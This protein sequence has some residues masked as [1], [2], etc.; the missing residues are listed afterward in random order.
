MYEVKPAESENGKVT[1]S[2]KNAA[3]G[4]EVTVTVTPNDGYELDKLVVKDKDGNEIEVT[5]KDGKYTFTMPASEVEITAEFKEAEP[6]T[7]ATDG[8]PFVDVP[9]DAYFRKAVE[10][11]LE[12]GV[13]GGTSPTTFSPKAQATRGQTMTFLWVSARP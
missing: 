11:A 7:P 8:F 1:V 4:D 9:E 3:E 6:E 12:N 10:W 5:E 13:T 2:P